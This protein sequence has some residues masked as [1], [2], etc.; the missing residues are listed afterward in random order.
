MLSI[1]WIFTLVTTTGYGD[2]Y[3]NNKGEYTISIFLMFGGVIIFGV[4]FFLVN[5]ILEGEYSFEVCI[6]EKFS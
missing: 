2:L 3:G 5:K 6:N 4:I 1:Y